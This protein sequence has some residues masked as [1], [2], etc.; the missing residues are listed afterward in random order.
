MEFANKSKKINVGNGIGNLITNFPI[1]N[2]IINYLNRFMD[3]YNTRFKMVKSHNDLVYIKSNNY[4]ATPNFNGYNYLL[5]FI[6][7]KGIFHCVLIDKKSIAKEINYN[8]LKI[9]SIKIRAKESLYNGTVLDGKLIKHNGTSTFIVLDCYLMMGSD[10]RTYQIEQRIK[11][12]E[13]CLGSITFDNNM[14]KIDIKLTKL[15]EFAQLPTLF[16][17]MKNSTFQLN[18]L[19]FLNRKNTNH[20][21]FLEE[22]N[23][24]SKSLVVFEVKKT[25]IPDVYELYCNSDKGKV[26]YGIAGIPTLAT[27]SLCKKLFDK[28]DT[29]NM[30]CEYCKQFKKWVPIDVENEKPIDKEGYIS[31]KLNYII[32]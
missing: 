26:R 7:I 14:N 18:G 32:R 17:K 31:N 28:T 2:D 6:K 30:K 23:N 27:S 25:D 1:K 29:L 5:V 20:Y 24:N 15:Y 19:I 22:S 16:D 3:P 13:E 10:I 21:V 12:I 9:I 8:D 4:V 11:K